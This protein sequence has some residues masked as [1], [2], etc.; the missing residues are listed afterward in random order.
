MVGRLNLDGGMLN[1]DEGMLTLD[2]GTHPPYNLSTVWRVKRERAP[3]AVNR[4][5]CAALCEQA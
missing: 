2:G 1:L 3:I 4:L 5:D